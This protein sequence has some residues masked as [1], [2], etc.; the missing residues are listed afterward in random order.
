M[1]DAYG[2]NRHGRPLLLASKVITL[3]PSKVFSAN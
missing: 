3:A 1:D 2:Q